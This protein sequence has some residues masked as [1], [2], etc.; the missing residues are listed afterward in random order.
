ML[1]QKK[2]VTVKTVFAMFLAVVLCFGMLSAVSGGTCV[3]KAE[4]YTWVDGTTVDA[5][6]KGTAYYFDF[7]TGSD[8]ATNGATFGLITM[9]QG[10]K[11][12][13]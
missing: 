6:E 1:K 8:W 5:P 2:S 13:L 12:G 7:T 10:T 9:N 11:H 3:V 4:D